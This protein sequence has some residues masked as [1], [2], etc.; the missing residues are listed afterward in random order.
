MKNITTIECF[1]VRSE[2]WFPPS[3]EWLING[4]PKHLSGFNCSAQL[5]PQAHS[6]ELLSCE[7][8]EPPRRDNPSV[9]QTAQTTEPPNGLFIG[10]NRL[11]I[12]LVLH[13]VRPCKQS[14]NQNPVLVSNARSVSMAG[15]D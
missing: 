4:H 7:T 9:T 2:V 12:G 6:S 11:F 1:I 10:G 8:H 5:E 15:S 14:R 13:Q 3:S